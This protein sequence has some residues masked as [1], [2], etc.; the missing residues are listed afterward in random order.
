MDCGVNL[1]GDMSQLQDPLTIDASHSK[2]AAADVQLGLGTTCNPEGIELTADSRCLFRNGIPWIP[3][4]GEF[5]YTRVP[6]SSRYSEDI[7]MAS[8]TQP[9]EKS[10][11]TST[12]GFQRV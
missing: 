8:V 6:H 10:T 1:Q 5:H 2:Q 7:R 3:V 9:L 11:E 4:M 12:V